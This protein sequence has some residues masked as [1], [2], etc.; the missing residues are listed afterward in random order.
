M[1][2]LTF[3]I[4]IGFELI[5][6]TAVFTVVFIKFKIL[7][8]GY[9]HQFNAWKKDI[10]LALVGT[11]DAYGNLADLILHSGPAVKNVLDDKKIKEFQKNGTKFCRVED[12]KNTLDF[13]H[14]RFSY[15]KDVVTVLPETYNI[16]D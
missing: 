14:S 9:N 1:L 4:V 8:L 3:P 11:L 15:N 7:M 13:K 6:S 12:T 10:S 16:I 2:L 5:V